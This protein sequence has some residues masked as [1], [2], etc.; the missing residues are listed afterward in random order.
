MQACLCMEEPA[1]VLATAVTGDGVAPANLR[2]SRRAAATLG[3][4]RRLRQQEEYDAAIAEAEAEAEAA[5]A[6]A[7]IIS[8]KYLPRPRRLRRARTTNFGRPE[9]F[10]NDL[11]RLE[12]SRCVARR[13]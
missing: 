11:G 6:A 12:R 8:S 5:P 4:Q 9:V 1:G 10:A 2:R 3:Q 13:V 7:P